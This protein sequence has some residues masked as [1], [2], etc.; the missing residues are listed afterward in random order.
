MQPPPSPLPN[1][2]A[3]AGGRPVVAPFARALSVLSAFAPGER[4][5]GNGDLVERTGLPASTVTRMTRTLVTLG[6]LRYAA[7]ADADEGAAPLAEAS[8]AMAP[9]GQD[10]PLAEV[11]RRRMR[12]ELARQVDELPATLREVFVLQ[13]LEGLPTAEVCSRLGIT[14]ANCWVRLHRARRRLAQRMSAHLAG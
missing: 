6:Y 10:D 13:V 1:C 3:A 4:W 9:A 8:A 11:G 5:L 7:G 2:A 14:E 12:A